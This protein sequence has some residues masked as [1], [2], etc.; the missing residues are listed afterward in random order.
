MGFFCDLEAKLAFVFELVFCKTSDIYS[1]V[2]FFIDKNTDNLPDG[3]VNIVCEGEEEA[4]SEFVDSIKQNTPSF[5]N[6]TIS[7]IKSGVDETRAFRAENKTILQ[8]FHLDTLQR[9]DSLD[10]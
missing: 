8:D 1:L 7:I 6:Q 5:A 2:K 10:V 4:M 3:S 9:F